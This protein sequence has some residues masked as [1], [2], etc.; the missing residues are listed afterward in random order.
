M[1]VNLELERLRRRRVIVDQFI[2][3]IEEYARLTA[4]PAQPLAAPERWDAPY[5]PGV[6]LV[7]AEPV[8]A[9]GFRH[10]L[11]SSSLQLST[12]HSDPAEAMARMDSG[13]TDLLVLHANSA[14][15]LDRVEPLLQRAPRS[16]VVLWVR[17][18]SMEVA[19]RAVGAG[20]RGILPTAFSSDRLL[21]ALHAIA[22]GEVRLELPS[23]AC[24]PVHTDMQLSKGQRKLLNLVGHGL[25]NKEIAAILGSTEGT[26]KTSLNRLHKALGL[27]DRLEVAFYAMQVQ[28]CADARP[29]SP[30]VT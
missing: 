17:R 25:K 20:I 29:A 19:G 4:P 1:G 15:V 13:C 28:A 24:Q 30:Y 18:I 12:I 7:S 23:K 10:L 26:V 8:V 14:A 16:A 6:T 27:K 21:E 22:S 5:G 3:L 2:E 9:E 11:S